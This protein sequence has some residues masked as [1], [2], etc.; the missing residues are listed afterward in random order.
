[1]TYLDMHIQAI[2]E[3]KATYKCALCDFDTPNFEI[4][5]KQQ[6]NKHADELKINCDMCEFKTTNESDLDRHRRAHHL[7]GQ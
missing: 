7:C 5:N 1:M 3:N 2:H 4:L 6:K